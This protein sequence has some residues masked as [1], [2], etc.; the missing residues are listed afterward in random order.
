MD[1]DSDLRDTR[2]NSEDLKVVKEIKL[3]T[4]AEHRRRLS[5]A[6]LVSAIVL[7]VVAAAALG[8]LLW[9]PEDP[10]AWAQPALFSILTAAIAF[11]FTDRDGG[12]RR[13]SPS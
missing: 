10:P 5:T 9:Y 12:D 3:A 6:R 8:S 2:F 13:D 7:P 4:A 11:L 1:D